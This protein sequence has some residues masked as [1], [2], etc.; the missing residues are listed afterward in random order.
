MADGVEHCLTAERSLIAEWAKDIRRA[1]KEAQVDTSAY[2]IDSVEN[3][4]EVVE[5]F[6]ANRGFLSSCLI[7]GTCS[8]HNF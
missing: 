4:Y 7:T 3:T 6:D 8:L 2:N 1:V 5:A